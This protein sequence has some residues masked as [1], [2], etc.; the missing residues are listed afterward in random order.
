MGKCCL[1]PVSVFNNYVF[2]A[3]CN[4]AAEL[5]S[6][7]IVPKEHSRTGER[8][9]TQIGPV[10]AGAGPVTHGREVPARGSGK[11]AVFLPFRCSLVRIT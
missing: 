9:T 1:M 8:C 6:A 5:H 3:H 4:S 2:V 10:I 7:A 11:W